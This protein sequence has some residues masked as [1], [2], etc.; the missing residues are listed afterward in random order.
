MP[1]IAYKDWEREMTSSDTDKWTPERMQNVDKIL[2]LNK[3][4]S[5]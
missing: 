5:R 3:K 4:Y 2:K 1:L